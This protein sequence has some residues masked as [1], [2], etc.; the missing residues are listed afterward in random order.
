MGQ[1]IQRLNREKYLEKQYGI[2]GENDLGR[3]IHVN[4]NEPKKNY[5]SDLFYK[6]MGC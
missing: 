1:V 5:S 3:A 2:K 4:N 6:H